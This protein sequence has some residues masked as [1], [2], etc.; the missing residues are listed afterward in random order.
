VPR[1]R[2]SST[3]G[4]CSTSRSLDGFGSEDAVVATYDLV[5]N[6]AAFEDTGSGAVSKPVLVT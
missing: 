5:D 2:P 6:K 1:N 3:Y 4:L